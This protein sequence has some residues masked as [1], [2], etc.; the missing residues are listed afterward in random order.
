[1]QQTNPEQITKI[2]NDLRTG[3]K[4]SEESLI[5]LVLPELRKRAARAMRGERPDHTLQATALVNEVYIRLV[6]TEQI[7]ENRAHFFAVAAII[8]RQI[9]ADH[10]RRRGSAKRGGAKRK[11]ELL[12][13]MAVGKCD[14]DSVLLVEQL[15]DRL[16]EWDRRQAKIVV[17]RY[18]GGLTEDEI[19]AVL[20]ISSRTVRRDWD[21][22]RSWLERSLDSGAAAG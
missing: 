5:A 2:L 17:F 4:A 6:G 14:L 15:L 1:M 20:G 12:D 11:L 3:D 13:W 18:Y 19:A 22:A 8:M 16:E 9:L 7:W 10:A 21:M